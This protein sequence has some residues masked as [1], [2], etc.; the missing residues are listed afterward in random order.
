MNIRKLAPS[1]LGLVFSGTAL[2]QITITPASPQALESVRIH[3]D[4][5]VLGEWF[6]FLPPEMSG[7]KITLAVLMPSATFNEFPIKPLETTLGQLPTGTYQVEVVQRAIDAVGNPASI[8]GTVG[9]AS[10]TVRQQT[11]QKT[12]ADNYSDLW[13]AP[14]E[15]GWGLSIHQHGSNNIFAVWFV[16]GQDGKAAWY[17]MPTGVWQTSLD[18]SGSIYRTTGPYFGNSVFDPKAVTVTPA[19]TATLSFSSTGTGSFA[20]TIDGVTGHKAIVRE[21]F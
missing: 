2:S 21:P 7:N 15:P 10:F 1:L 5:N 3:V 14:A 19:G 8:L 6:R 13:W 9:T 11:G 20:F 17:A 16:Y 18:Y 4:G 12:P